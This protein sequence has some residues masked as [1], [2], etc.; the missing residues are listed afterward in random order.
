MSHRTTHPSPGSGSRHALAAARPAVA[1]QESPSRGT[2]LA[3][4]D[5]ARLAA[6]RLSPGEWRAEV[7]WG[8]GTPREV[9]SGLSPACK[10]RLAAQAWAEQ[11]ARVREEPPAL[12]AGPFETEQEARE[13]PAA[14]HARAE[15]NIA[16]DARPAVTRTAGA[17]AAQRAVDAPNL[18]MLTD[19]CEA[20][21]VGLGAYDRR[22]LAWLAG[23]EPATCAVL[24]GIIRRAGGGAS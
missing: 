4:L 20:A 22:I 5:G 14:R 21:G 13:S 10:T 11:A 24:A 18:A 9:S 15:T 12:S 6:T 8:P 19:A 1:W 2:W 3:A 7:V 23:W 17:A 16:V